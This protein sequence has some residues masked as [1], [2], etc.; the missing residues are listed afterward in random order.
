MSAAALMASGA[1]LLA[2]AISA[3][4]VIRYWSIGAMVGYGVAVLWV[5]P[6]A[7]RRAAHPITNSVRNF[8]VPL[9]MGVGSFQLLQRALPT[10]GVRLRRR[11]AAQVGMEEG[12]LG[13]FVDGPQA[14][15][16]PGRP[17]ALLSFATLGP[18]PA[19]HDQ[20][21][22]A[23]L[24]ELSGALMDAAVGGGKPHPEEPADADVGQG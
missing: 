24:E 5:R 2:K 6:D 10:P 3:A 4:G 1:A 18:T 11:V 14:Q 9:L 17:A 7:G 8:M 19:H 22:L 23:H 16:H 20:L 21:G 12:E 13:A 15:L